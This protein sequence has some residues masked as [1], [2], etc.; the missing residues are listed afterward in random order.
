M[1]FIT[2]VFVMRATWLLVVSIQ[3]FCLYARFADP[4]SAFLSFVGAE[5]AQAASARA[6]ELLGVKSD[7]A[8]WVCGA[9][10]KGIDLGL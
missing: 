8:S 4:I 2:I 3:S 9:S 6:A 7:E 10:E 1:M 5:Q